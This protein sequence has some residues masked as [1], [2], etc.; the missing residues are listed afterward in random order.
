MHIA[1]YAWHMFRQTASSLPSTFGKIRLH[2]KHIFRL[3]SLITTASPCSATRGRWYR[4]QLRRRW[5]PWFSTMYSAWR[6]R[7]STTV[8]STRSER[9]RDGRR[10]ASC[11]ASP[12]KSEV[13][14]LSRWVVESSDSTLQISV[15]PVQN[16]HADDLRKQR[17]PANKNPSRAEA[18]SS[19]RPTTPLLPSLY[20]PQRDAK[21]VSFRQPTADHLP[22][23]RPI[24]GYGP[25][26]HFSMGI[27]AIIGPAH[28]VHFCTTNGFC[29]FIGGG[30]AHR[31]WI[32]CMARGNVDAF[33]NT[34]VLR[35][36]FGQKANAALLG[37]G[38][39]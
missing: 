10:S 36:D 39:A 2:E 25:A 11:S 16:R 29:R 26:L 33:P 7:D 30:A 37:A 23:D 17:L 31:G 18:H 20:H 4:T 35:A 6:R 21:M 22:Q 3:C 14:D 27:S 5:Y 34:I 8:V 1:E 24:N 9:P 12:R 32:G 13:A 38:R 15:E 19:L 28:D